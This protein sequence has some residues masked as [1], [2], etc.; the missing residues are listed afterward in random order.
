MSKVKN[1]K[2]SKTVKA[3][4][5]EYNVDE[6]IVEIVLGSMLIST[7]DFNDGM[8]LEKFVVLFGFVILLVG[9]F[10]LIPKY[11]EQNKKG[12]VIILTVVGIVA[13]VTLLGLVLRLFGLV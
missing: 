2:K 3:V 13:I 8:L 11:R 4:K 6:N 9:V 5:K 7:S 10:R 1:T 12:M